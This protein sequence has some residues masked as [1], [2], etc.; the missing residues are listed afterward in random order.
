MRK[1]VPE[2]LFNFVEYKLFLSHLPL[3]GLEVLGQVLTGVLPISPLLHDRLVS[4]LQLLTHLSGIIV[5][6]L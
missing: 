3:D 2:F 1:F 4:F 5:G 6:P